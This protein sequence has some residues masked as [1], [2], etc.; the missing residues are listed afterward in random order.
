MA[1]LAGSN[2]G[3]CAHTTVAAA[4]CCPFPMFFG[5]AGD[6][7]FVP[8]VRARAARRAGKVKGGSPPKGPLDRPSTV[9]RLAQEQDVVSTVQIIMEKNG[10][11]SAPASQ[12]SCSRL[13]LASLADA[14]SVITSMTEL[15]MRRSNWQW[16]GWTAQAIVTGMGGD[17]MAAPSS[18]RL[19]AR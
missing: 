10:S 13:L 15:H 3:K 4:T 6:C 12:I 7:S 1:S 11:A 5:S 2:F 9:R 17:A 16:I 14:K 18:G 8:A 19:A